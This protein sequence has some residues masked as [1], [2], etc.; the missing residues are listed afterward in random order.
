MGRHP[1]IR[2]ELA[3]VLGECE[4]VSY[5]AS[6]MRPLANRWR[7]V[8]P[9]LAALLLTGVLLSGLSVQKHRAELAQDATTDA[10]I[11][12]T[13]DCAYPWLQKMEERMRLGSRVARARLELHYRQSA[14]RQTL[15]NAR[16]SRPR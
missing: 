15:S 11:D 10:C 12:Q 13:G 4:V 5:D 3:Q 14:K 8:P 6:Q 9:S 1:Q 16:I 7:F 2:T